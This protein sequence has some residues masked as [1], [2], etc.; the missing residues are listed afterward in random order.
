M[1]QSTAADRALTMFEAFLRHA[2]GSNEAPT[3]AH[4]ASPA[5]TAPPPPGPAARESDEALDGE[6]TR[7]APMPTRPAVTTSLPTWDDRTEESAGPLAAHAPVEER[8]DLSV[9]LPLAPAPV[10]AS[11]VEERSI[12]VDEDSLTSP[13]MSR[14]VAFA[15]APAALAPGPAGLDV[16]L[17][18]MAVLVK[19]GHAPQAA[20]E[21]ELWAAAHADDLAGHMRVAE[22]EMAR[23]DRERAL[24]RYGTLISLFLDRADARSAN[25]VLRRLRR[26]MPGDPR[27]SAI[28]QW[29]GIS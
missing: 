18:E 15:A 2:R 9:K 8:T 27:V 13:E 4:R 6:V 22:F 14:D 3:A 17:R 1:V 7:V 19:Y 11:H 28:A 23:I 26:D 10:H 21:L 25:D 24:Q 5:R 20:Q 12:I 16:L 29:N